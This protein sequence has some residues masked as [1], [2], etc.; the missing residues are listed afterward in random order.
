VE[1]S[2]HGAPGSHPA[3]QAYYARIQ[4]LAKTDPRIRLLPAFPNHEVRG[5]LD[6]IDALVV[7]SLW[8]ENTPLVVYEAFAAGCPV[9]GSEVEGIAEIVGHEVNGLLF[10]PGDPSGL[11]SAIRRLAENRGLLRA[12]ASRTM[13]PLSVPAHVSRLE[14]I[15]LELIAARE[16][17]AVA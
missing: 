9:I 1:L 4:A 10:A 14:E 11:A 6:T 12:L 16:A 15:Y 8:H 3:Y 2:I 13:P 7:P 5:V 17:S